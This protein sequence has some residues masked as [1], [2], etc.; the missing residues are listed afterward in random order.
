MYQKLKVI[1]SN[2]VFLYLISRYITFF[3]QFL[4]SILI[5]LKFG[6][7][8]LGIWGF[9][10][11]LIN[12]ISYVNFGIPYS[13]NILMVQSKSN[14]IEVKNY[15]AD[16]LF[17]TLIL[18]ILILVIGIIYFLFGF[19]YF[20]KYEISYYFYIVCFIGIIYHFNSLFGTIYRVRN[21]IFEL[22]FFQSAVPILVF[23]SLFLT[24]GKKLLDLMLIMTLIGQLSTLFIFLTNKQIPFGGKIS[25]RGIK[26]VLNKGVYL[27]IYNFCFFMIILSTRT[28]ISNFYKVEE[29]GYFSFSYNISNSIL[30]FLQAL[31]VVIFPKIIDKLNSQSK[32]NTIITLKNIFNNYVTISYGLTFVAII[33]Y[34][35]FLYLI[36]RYS[37]TLIELELISLSLLLFT[38][39]FGYSS[40]LMANNHEKILSYISIFSLL[41]NISL[42]LFLIYFFKITYEYIILST[43]LSY[44]IFSFFCAYYTKKLL[45]EG[46][47][48]FD[49]FLE[50]FPIRLFLPFLSCFILIFLKSVIFISIPLVLFLIL[51]KSQINEIIVTCKIIIFK[52][53]FIDFDD[54]S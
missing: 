21:K 13:V 15:V 48:F 30:L 29:F 44:F 5:A 11:L 19:N 7:Y 53:S 32:E 38:N 14:T 3:L 43:L 41:I 2:K 22:A 17:L 10:S 46:T 49:V 25:Y 37:N 52:P 27:F 36:P 8:Y 45:K 42:S 33:L 12:Y 47:S 39:S 54:K 24:T 20:D 9:L 34:P 50:V 26:K 51:N 40:Y 35:L 6:P 28:I 4:T 18:S 23:I 1:A 31:S 16:S